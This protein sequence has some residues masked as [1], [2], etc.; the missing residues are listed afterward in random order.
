MHRS[1]RHFVSLAA[2]VSLLLSCHAGPQPSVGIPTALRADSD[3][4]DWVVAIPTTFK[5]PSRD[6]VLISVW[7]PILERFD[8]TS[9][10]PVDV[11]VSAGYRE[12][13]WLVAPR[14]SLRVEVRKEDSGA[15]RVLLRREPVGSG[16]YRLKFEWWKLK[17]SK[18]GKRQTLISNPFTL[19]VR[20]ARARSNT[21]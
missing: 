2:T 12:P 10:R 14:D 17:R 6:T 5:N 11:P 3:D 9:W 15:Q 1:H 19:T 13:T 18:E 8:G 16:K 4:S 20:D 7:S 21:R